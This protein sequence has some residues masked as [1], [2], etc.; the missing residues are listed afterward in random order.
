MFEVG[1][2]WLE[3][4][5]YVLILTAGRAAVWLEDTGGWTFATAGEFRTGT[6]A[7]VATVEERML[8]FVTLFSAEIGDVDSTPSKV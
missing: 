3:D 7:V 5:G 6:S 1:T 4:A 2:A 8:V